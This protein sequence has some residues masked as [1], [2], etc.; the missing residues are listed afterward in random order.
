MFD[1]AFREKQKKNTLEESLNQAFSNYRFNPESKNPI[2]LGDSSIQNFHELNDEI[3]AAQISIEAC[4]GT[5]VLVLSRMLLA[6][7]NDM[8]ATDEAWEN[9]APLEVARFD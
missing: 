9:S 1:S 7:R 8:D 4:S 5:V 3:E 2:L 6:M